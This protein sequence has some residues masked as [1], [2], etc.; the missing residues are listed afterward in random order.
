[1]Y[2]ALVLIWQEKKLPDLLTSQS[3]PSQTKVI[4]Q[5][6]L[7][8]I[9][10]HC[11]P[12]ILHRYLVTLFGNTCG[13]YT[14]PIWV[15]NSYTWKRCRWWKTWNTLWHLAFIFRSQ[16]SIQA[17]SSRFDFIVKVFEKMNV[18]ERDKKR[19]KQSR[20]MIRQTW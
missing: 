5:C 14:Y 12:S 15:N 8:L 11:L 19:T 17:A 10:L 13:N 16:N 9:W 4:S 20:S 3:R 2:L 6:R 7:K 1:M 18:E